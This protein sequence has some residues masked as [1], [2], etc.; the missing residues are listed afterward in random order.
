ML[1]FSMGLPVATYAD[2]EAKPILK[3]MSANDMTYHVFESPHGTANSAMVQL[4]GWT[5]GIQRFEKGKYSVHDWTYWYH[6]V[7]YVI[8]GRGQVTVSSPPYVASEKHT[9]ERGDIFSVAPS[10]RI[11]M[12]ALGDEVL[13]VFFAVP[14]E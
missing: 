10:M 8:R 5:G 12:E 4:P 3:I 13:E 2:T 11:S 1:V 7:L 14:A 9:L 6:E